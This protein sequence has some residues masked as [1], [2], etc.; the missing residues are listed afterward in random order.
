[1]TGYPS[2]SSP[3]SQPAERLSTARLLRLAAFAV[4]I[5]AAAQ[6]VTR[7]RP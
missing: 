1:M 3:W 7:E 4:P 5:Y 2:S 6:P